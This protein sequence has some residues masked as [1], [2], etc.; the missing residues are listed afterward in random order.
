MSK[1]P[2]TSRKLS[3]KCYYME[4]DMRWIGGRSYGQ[5]GSVVF[6]RFE[7]ILITEQYDTVKF[8]V[9]ML[10]FAPNLLLLHGLSSKIVYFDE[11]I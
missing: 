7:I 6:A 9:L 3:D 11:R 10:G 1:F 5:C 2:R 8:T 4:L